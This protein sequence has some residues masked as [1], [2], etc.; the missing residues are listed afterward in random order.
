M[1]ST[2]PKSPITRTIL[3]LLRVLPEFDQKVTRVDNGINAQICSRTMSR[4]SVYLYLDMTVSLM[5]VVNLEIRRLRYNRSIRSP[6]SSE[7]VFGPLAQA[8]FVSNS[9]EDHVAAQT[10][11]LSIS[12]GNHGR[13][14]PGLHVSSTATIQAPIDNIST[15]RIV[16]IAHQCYRIYVPIEHKALSAARTASDTNNRRTT[17]AILNPLFR[18]VQ[19]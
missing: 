13:C 4:Q 11:L 9:S 8:L 3:Q 17:F 6:S 7:D 1:G 12:Q 19:E 16:S 14:N 5:G 15:E 18:L 10:E 2:R